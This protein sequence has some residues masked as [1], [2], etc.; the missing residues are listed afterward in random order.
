MGYYVK[1]VEKGVKVSNKFVKV[2]FVK[3]FGK[4]EFLFVFE[5]KVNSKVKV[6][7]G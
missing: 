7:F 1:L 6:K 4:V 3:C 5:V 2:V